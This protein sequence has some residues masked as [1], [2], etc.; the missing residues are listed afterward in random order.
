MK[1]RN[2][3]QSVTINA[4]P[5]EVYEALVDPKKHARFTGASAKLQRK[6]GGRFT[7]YDESLEG[8]VVELVPDQRVTLAWRSTEWPEGHYSIAQFEVKKSPKGTRLDF[9]QTGIPE[10]DFEGIRD[11]WKQYYWQPLKSYFET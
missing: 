6:A 2:L 10:S 8:V 3:K 9:T 5:H 4:D 7:A 1:S 11:G